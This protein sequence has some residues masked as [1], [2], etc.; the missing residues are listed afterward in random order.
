MIIFKHILLVILS[1]LYG[2]SLMFVNEAID[3]NKNKIKHISVIILAV[4]CLLSIDF[5][6]Y[7]FEINYY[8]EWLCYLIMVI[9]NVATPICMKKFK[10][11][12]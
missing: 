6:S 8:I 7:V 4:A 5:M 3:I 11:S 9:I 1:I 12:K 10:K 2:V